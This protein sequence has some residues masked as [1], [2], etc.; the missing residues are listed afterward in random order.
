[1]IFYL[2]T[3]FSLEWVDLDLQVQ[4]GTLTSEGCPVAVFCAVD[5]MSS[6][7]HNWSKTNIASNDG[8]SQIQY[9]SDRDTSAFLVC[10]CFFRLIQ[11]HLS[12][13]LFFLLPFCQRKTEIK[14]K[15]NSNSSLKAMRCALLFLCCSTMLISWGIEI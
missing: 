12:L 3:S 11:D 6:D 13:D 2:N 5:Y 8:I 1:M 7:E 9:L 14:K 10:I 15:K 4:C